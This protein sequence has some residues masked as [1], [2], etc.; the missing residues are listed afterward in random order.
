MEVWAGQ[1]ALDAHGA[2]MIEDVCLYM[3]QEAA[4]LQVY[5]GVTL[6]FLSLV[7]P[8]AIPFHLVSGPHLDVFTQ[9]PS[10]EEWFSHN[11]LDTC[12]VDFGEKVL[13]APWWTRQCGQSSVGVLLRVDG[14][15]VASQNGRRVSELLIYGAIP[16]E[17]RSD[18]VGILTPPRS[19]SPAIDSDSADN[20][21]ASQVKTASL[22]ALPLSSD[23]HCHFNGAQ[24]PQSPPA[25][26]LA[27]G[28]GRFLP[29]HPVEENEKNSS[30]RKRQRLDSLFEDATQQRKRAKRR[31]GE[32]VA[33]AMASLNTAQN[34]N[35]ENITGTINSVESGSN[36]PTM[37]APNKPGHTRN[38]GITRTQSLGSLR[39]FDQSRPSSGGATNSLKRSSLHRM[40]SVGVC[41][42]SSPA[43]EDL[44]GIEQ[45]NKHALARVVMAGMRMYGLQQKKKLL[46]T[47]APFEAPSGVPHDSLSAAANVDEDDY[48][49]VYHQT[50]KAVSFAL[51]R[52]ISVLGI[53]QEL[54]RD[55]VDQFL[56]IF[57]VDPTQK[58]QESKVGQEGFGTEAH[59]G[60]NAFDSPSDIGGSQT[61]IICHVTPRKNTGNGATG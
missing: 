52:Q 47:R 22:Y 61:S 3:S 14:D 51:R 7:D 2:D 9:N 25:D 5:P 42:S 21:D 16:R 18:Q 30:Q 34:G 57:C 23:L 10:T 28:F 26:D 6:N 31:G 44:N 17:M 50:Y 12:P 33:E 40:A 32:S 35:M 27:E 4:S 43:P 8:T 45:Q 54:M 13:E 36:S 1:I 49:L 38:L 58:A 60:Q 19:S 20:D 59:M 39:D 29:D 55:L 15:M 41:E 56:E 53:A 24:G 11:I 46:N 37:M 48:K